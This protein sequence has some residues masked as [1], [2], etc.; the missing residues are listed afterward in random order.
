MRSAHAR[1]TASGEGKAGRLDES[2][3]IAAVD[4][5]LEVAESGGV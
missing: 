5:G 4:K 1:E 3:G 2:T